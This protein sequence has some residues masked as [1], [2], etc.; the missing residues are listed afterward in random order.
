MHVNVLSS[1]AILY[2]CICNFPVLLSASLG[3]QTATYTV[4]THQH[5]QRAKKERKMAGKRENKREKKQ[6][7][8]ISISDCI[9]A[10]V[11]L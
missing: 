8:F 3:L 11:G 2:I 9:A 7:T 6:S 10:R 5:S 4:G 1:A